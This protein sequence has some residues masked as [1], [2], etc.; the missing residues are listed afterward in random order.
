MAALGA[1]ESIFRLLNNTTKLVNVLG[2][3]NVSIGANDPNYSLDVNRPIGSDATFGLMDGDVTQPITSLHPTNTFFEAKPFNSTGGGALLA[4]ISDGDTPGFVINGQLGTNS[5]SSSTAAFRV[6][7]A[8]S[9]GTTGVSDLG[10]S[11]L[12]FEFVN[13]SLTSFPALMCTGGRLCGMS[14]Q[15][16]QARLDISSNGGDSSTQ[17]FQVTNSGTGNPIFRVRNDSHVTV[18]PTAAGQTAFLNV[19]APNTAGSSADA[20][21]INSTLAAFNGSD[22][23]TGL[24]INITNA[25]HTGTGNT[26]YG[27]DIPGITFDA[28]ET[29]TAI[30]VGSGGWNYGLE[31]P[32]NIGIKLGSANIV[33][34]GSDVS[35]DAPL[36]LSSSLIIGSGDAITKHISLS[37]AN[38]TSAS[39][40]ASACGDYATISVTGAAVGDSVTA[41]PDGDSSASGI[42][43]SNLSWNAYVS[44]TNTVTIRAC[45]PTA[46][47]IDNGND[48]TWRVDVWKH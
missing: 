2:S 6:V 36:N 29:A 28:D 25:N 9:N 8:K 44:A 24:K 40:S 10:N 12:L 19:T 18:G 22:N 13:N 47:P 30:R 5:P 4:G 15:T 1:S 23:Y 26:L 21:D 27:I 48:Q 34:G 11:D 35:I 37:Q 32:T 46:S 20:I 42:E 17:S 41:T 33:Y 43:D 7:G 31:L 3:G 16:P 38:V 45:N 14:T 39:I